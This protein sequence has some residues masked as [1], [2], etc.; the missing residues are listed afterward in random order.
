[1]NADVHAGLDN[2]ST[3]SSIGIVRCYLSP[4]C[5]SVCLSI[6]LYLFLAAGR[7]GVANVVVLLLCFCKTFAFTS[8]F[9]FFFTTRSEFCPLTSLKVV[10]GISP[11]RVG[12][13]S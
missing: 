6:C 13:L 3:H 1:M 5:L 9:L 8:F 11:L 2:S 12:F 10:F 4:V 7:H